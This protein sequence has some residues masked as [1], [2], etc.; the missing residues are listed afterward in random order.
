[1]SNSNSERKDWEA[2]SWKQQQFHTHTRTL[3]LTE[4]S[5]ATII[6]WLFIAEMCEKICSV[7]ET[8]LSFEF[9]LLF[10]SSYL[11]N[12]AQSLTRESAINT[13]FLVRF[14]NRYEYI[15]ISILLLYVCVII[16]S[17]CLTEWKKT[18]Y[19]ISRSVWRDI[20]VLT[21]SPFR[22]TLFHIHELLLLLL[23]LLLL[24]I[25]NERK[26]ISC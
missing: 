22:S 23:P 26:A 16:R 10:S 25:F 17:K 3:S 13:Y 24:W 5:P 14:S 7:R 4:W 6:H 1:M 15:H 18:F 19:R 20:F 8:K 11:I 9:L 2:V 12:Y 21:F